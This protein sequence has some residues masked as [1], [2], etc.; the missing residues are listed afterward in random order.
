MSYLLESKP[1][2]GNMLLLS[3][4]KSGESKLAHTAVNQAMIILNNFV[5]QFSFE[6]FAKYIQERK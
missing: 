6:D 1:G 4:D 5:F 3:S 2:T